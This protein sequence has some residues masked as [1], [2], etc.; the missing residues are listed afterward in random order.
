MLTVEGLKFVLSKLP[1]DYEIWVRRYESPFGDHLVGKCSFE[2]DSK[3]GWIIFSGG[4]DDEPL[5]EILEAI[6]DK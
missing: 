1:P 2:V 6:N 5:Q 4:D 3:N